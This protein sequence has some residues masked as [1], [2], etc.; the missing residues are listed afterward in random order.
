MAVKTNDPVQNENHSSN[1]KNSNLID[2]EI[3]SVLSRYSDLFSST[4]GRIV[5]HKINV[6]LHPGAQPKVFKAR[7]VPF[8]MKKA[9]EQELDRLV[10]Q[11]II[12][13]VDPSN[14]EIVWASPIVIA[15]KAN[16]K[17]RLCADFKVSI[18]KYIMEDRHPMP[19]LDEV[20]AQISGGEQFSVVD[21]KD[22]FTYSPET[23]DTA[24]RQ[25]LGPLNGAYV[26]KRIINFDA[27]NPTRFYQEGLRNLNFESMIWL[28]N[29]RP[30][31]VTSL[32]DL[33]TI[34]A[35]TVRDRRSPPFTVQGPGSMTRI[36]FHFRTTSQDKCARRLGTG[37]PGVNRYKNFFL[38]PYLR[39]KMHFC[40][41]SVPEQVSVCP[42]V[43]ICNQC[44]L[45]NGRYDTKGKG[46]TT[47]LGFTVFVGQAR[48]PHKEHTGDNKICRTKMCHR[49]LGAP[50]SRITIFY[51]H[52]ILCSWRSIGNCTTAHPRHH[53]M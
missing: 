26:V 45:E 11:G 23:L 3:K 4:T 32:E 16:G 31:I 52:T 49:P 14:T 48:G 43:V 7:P 27:T 5:G 42:S 21:L 41:E 19:T 22:A 29:P 6:Q 2:F 30:K 24:M 9:V 40:S 44:N 18:N 36:G 1:V 35:V 20:R 15:P 37:C 38:L 25:V 28:A 39:D 53:S 12:E 50:P 51:T 47:I 33:V 13:P 10:T 8:A 17:I 46:S 34:D